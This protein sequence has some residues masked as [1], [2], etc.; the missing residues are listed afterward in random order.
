M[1]TL[2]LIFLINSG[3]L[4][5]INNPEFLDRDKVLINKKIN[6]ENSL[7]DL[8]QILGKPLKTEPM[9][10]EAS[11]YN[12]DKYEL[13]TYESLEFVV[14]DNKALIQR[15]EFNNDKVGAVFPQIIL[16]NKTDITEIEKLFPISCKMMRQSNSTKINIGISPKLNWDDKWILTFEKGKLKTIFYNILI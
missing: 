5:Q 6:Y 16:T 8:L 11:Q 15:I 12:G 2:L 4:F 9:E 3:F 1:K 13:Y 10:D 14:Y 7:V